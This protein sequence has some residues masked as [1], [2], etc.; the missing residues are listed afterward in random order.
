MP[1]WT[2]GLVVVVVVV[3]MVGVLGLSYVGGRSG[4]GFLM[5]MFYRRTILRSRGCE[6]LVSCGLV[7]GACLNLRFCSEIYCLHAL[8]PASR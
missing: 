7:H 1:F 4:L 2:P 6:Y 5:D 3:M 8:H